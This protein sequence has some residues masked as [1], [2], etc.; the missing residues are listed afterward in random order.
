MGQP[1]FYRAVQTQRHL[2]V[3]LA[4]WVALIGGLAWLPWSPWPLV[5]AVAALVA[6]VGARA[7]RARS[8]SDACLGQVVWQVTAIAM[9]RGFLA[10]TRSPTELVEAVVLHVPAASATAPQRSGPHAVGG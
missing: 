4:L 8:L 10:R 5:A 2:F 9:V 6:L 7:V 1:Y 3:A